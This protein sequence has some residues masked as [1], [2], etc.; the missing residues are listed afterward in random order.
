MSN[1]ALQ[2]IEVSDV[3]PRGGGYAPEID[4][5]KYLRIGWLV[6]VLGMGSFFAWASLAP[7]D[8]GVPASGTVITDGNRKT[9]QP[10]AGGM[11][12]DVLVKDG[13][14]VAEGQ[15]LVRL[16]D[17]QV[18]AQA[19]GLREAIA[20][21][22]SLMR[23]LNESRENKR[24][25]LKIVNEQLGELRALAKDGYVPRTRVLELERLAAQLNGAISEDIGNLG[26]YQRQISE[27]RERMNASEF[28]VANTVV[29]A[30]AAGMVQGLSIFTR[31]GVVSAGAKLMEVVPLDEMLVIE[32]QVPTNLI[33]KVGVGL[34]V[35]IMFPAFNVATTPNIPGKV[36][37]VSAD[38]F[39]E[40]RT[41]V[42]YYKVRA[43]VTP[44][45]MNMLK[46]LQI[47]PGMPAELFVKTGERTLMSYMLKPMLD[48]MHTS[49]REE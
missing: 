48:R 21:V 32:G 3:E 31:G 25:Q 37:V 23:G 34:D 19:N 1:L 12:T 4:D 44:E 9:V 36:T 18:Q 5:R 6:V 28:E 17:V 49:L 41:G 10:L 39:V 8:K 35:E 16:S 40:E 29:K 7:L 30:P 14:I 47:R 43:Q 15:P 24:I 22:E 2:K 42:P 11:V 45:G 26:R 33:D 46:G 13:D 27:F 20:G 38:R